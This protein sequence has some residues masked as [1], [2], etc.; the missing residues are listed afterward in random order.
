M[1]QKEA[2]KKEEEGQGWE[3]TGKKLEGERWEGRVEPSGKEKK[4]E[5]WGRQGA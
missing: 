3:R 1:T 5:R 4:R 2:E